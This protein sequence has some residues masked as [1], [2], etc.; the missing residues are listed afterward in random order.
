MAT[1]ARQAAH[2][3][4]DRRATPRA[5]FGRTGTLRIDGQDPVE[6]TVS[7][8]TRDGCCI[9]TPAELERNAS[10]SIGLANVGLTPCRIVWKSSRG[11][12]C[13]FDAPLSA[14]AVT[15]AFGPSNI[16]SFPNQSA[17]WNAPAA[18][19]KWSPRAR[20][21]LLGI[22]VTACWAAVAAGTFLLFG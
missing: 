20:M 6:V 4:A 18:T 19:A 3:F 11:Y 5:A 10:A 21:S 17:S 16:A 8:L 1:T 14:G 15:S 22:A 12:G 2:R 13:A 9:Q 7:D